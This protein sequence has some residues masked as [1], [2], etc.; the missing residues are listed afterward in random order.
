VFAC[1]HGRKSNRDSPR[2]EPS[3]CT[4]VGRNRDLA[5]RSRC[6]WC[7]KKLVT[8][9]VW[10][11]NLLVGASSR[12]IEA[13]AG[14]LAKPVAVK[15][16][17]VAKTKKYARSRKGGTSCA[18]GMAGSNASEGKIKRMPSLPRLLMS[19]DCEIITSDTMRVQVAKASSA[20]PSLLKRSPGFS[21][22]CNMN[23]SSRATLLLLPRRKIAI[24]ICWRK[25]DN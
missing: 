22:S 18:T 7:E 25:T 13:R 24:G 2:R 14:V 21:L 8:L 12:R 19:D 1:A 6:I 11:Q 9:A 10:S 3:G 5:E 15:F 4:Q 20:I 16:W 17:R 23:P